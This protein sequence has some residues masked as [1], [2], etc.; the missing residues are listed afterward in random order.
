VPYGSR[1][2]KRPDLQQCVLST[3]GV[4]R[5]VPL[6]GKPEDGTASE[7][8]RK[9]TRLAEIA[10][11]RAPS[12]VHPGASSSRADAALVTAAHRAALRDPVVI[13]RFPATDG[14]GGRGMA[15]AVARNQWTER[16]IRA[17]TPPTKPRPGTS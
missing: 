5:A 1:Q 13:P 11:R 4:D 12:G 8:T 14:E 7:K 16:G 3:L 9:T 10:P 15:E 17:Q 6:W 2:E